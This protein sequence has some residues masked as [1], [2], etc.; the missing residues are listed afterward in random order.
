M[1]KCDAIVLRVFFCVQISPIFVRGQH[2]NWDTSPNYSVNHY[3]ISYIVLPVLIQ[4]G[5]KLFA[6]VEMRKTNKR[7]K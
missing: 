4:D 3:Y 7:Q 1:Y 2:L 5:T 6:C